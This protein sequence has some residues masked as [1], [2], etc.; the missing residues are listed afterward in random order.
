MAGPSADRVASDLLGELTAGRKP[1]RAL[2]GLIAASLSEEDVVLSDAAR[3]AAEWVV[4]TPERRGEALLDLLLL[5]DRLPPS[6][7]GRDLRFP[8]LESA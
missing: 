3:S 8:R 6:K 2:R 1:R 7:R 5:T 4:A